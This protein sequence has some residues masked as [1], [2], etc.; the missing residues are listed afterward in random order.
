MIIDLIDKLLDRA[1]QLLKEH[2]EARREFFENF[3][4]PTY[5]LCQDVH[6][7]Y[8]KCFEA[9]RATIDSAS[10]FKSVV[11]GLCAAIKK[12]NLFTEHHRAKLRAFSDIKSDVPDDKSLE[13]LVGAIWFYL[14][15]SVAYVHGTEGTGDNVQEAIG[16][17]IYR[18]SLFNQLREICAKPHLSN[19]ERKRDALKQLD[20]IVEAMQSK[21]LYVTFTYMQLKAQYLK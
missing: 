7:E 18:N 6:E 17:Q 12:D 19:E 15:E 5:A 3:V 13:Q 9:Y 8:L 11:D 16:A 2:K 10:D 1:I 14:Y 20:L 4:E 21:F